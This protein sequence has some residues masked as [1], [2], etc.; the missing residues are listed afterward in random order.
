MWAL[1]KLSNP[2]YVEAFKDGMGFA[3]ISVLSV[4]LLVI[5]IFRVIIFFI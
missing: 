1:K 4:A 3:V 5:V 2:D